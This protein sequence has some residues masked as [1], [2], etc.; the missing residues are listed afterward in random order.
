MSPVAARNA[1]Q[2]GDKIAIVAT[3]PG[4]CIQQYAL[5]VATTV[6][7]HSNPE[8]TGQFTAVT[9]TQKRK[10]GKVIRN[11]LNSLSIERVINYQTTI[12]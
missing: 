2:P 1:E 10:T 12:Q 8:K 7:Y 3:V 11:P 6:K 5:I 9:V 4:R